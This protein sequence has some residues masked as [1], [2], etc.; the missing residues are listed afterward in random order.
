MVFNVVPTVFEVSLVGGILAYKCGPQFV[1]LTVA[2]MAAYTYYTFTVTQV[3]L[4]HIQSHT[5]GG[6]EAAWCITQVGGRKQHGVRTNLAPTGPSCHHV[7]G[8]G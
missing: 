6:E 8:A 4:L 1:A 3:H 5:G 7:E 2:T